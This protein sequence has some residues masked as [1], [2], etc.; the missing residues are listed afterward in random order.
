MD[1][2]S[3]AQCAP[4]PEDK[5]LAKPPLPPCAHPENCRC[6]LSLR[7]VDITQ[8]TDLDI[9]SS[10]DEMFAVEDLHQ[11][12]R[13]V[14]IYGGHWECEKWR[15]VVMSVIGVRPEGNGVET[16]LYPKPAPKPKNVKKSEKPQKRSPGGP[17]FFTDREIYTGPQIAKLRPKE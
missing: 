13:L 5:A 14:G 2:N 7:N 15:A 8:L 11:R 4:P 16:F 9:C 12:A 1:S 17:G 3:P 6:Q 10:L